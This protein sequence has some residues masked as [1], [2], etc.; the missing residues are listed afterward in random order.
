MSRSLR[1]SA[2][3]RRTSRSR[4]VRLSD[5]RL[6]HRIRRGARRRV[7]SEE[8]AREPPRHHE[9][10]RLRRPERS[11]Q[12]LRREVLGQVAARAVAHRVGH[13]AIGRRTWS[14]SRSWCWAAAGPAPGRAPRRTCPA[15]RCPG[16][17]CPGRPAGASASASSADEASATTTMPSPAIA[18]ATADRTS[19]WS[20]TTITR[21]RGSGAVIPVPAA[22]SDADAREGRGQDDPRARLGR[23]GDPEPAADE[24][25][26]LAHRREAVALGPDRRH[27]EPVPVVGDAE[28][29]PVVA[30]HEA[31]ADHGG[32][33]VAGDVGQCLLGDPQDLGLAPR[34]DRA[35]CDRP[36]R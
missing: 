36:R 6:A 21:I 14:A 16:A 1:P 34:R 22:A 15:A 9:L 31:H 13:V 26:P 4:A 29:D 8:T 32:V 23:G 18:F 19:G 3:R 2:S 17:G 20:S 12:R 27:V 35:S 24:C 11:R 7:L 28:R 10:A 5:G 30:D 25:G 33:G